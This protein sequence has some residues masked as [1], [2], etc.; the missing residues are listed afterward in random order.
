MS[1]ELKKDYSI[2]KN[3]TTPTTWTVNEIAQALTSQ[4]KGNKRIEVPTFQ[5]SLVWSDEQ[6][7]VFIDSLRNGFP[8]GTL[9][10]YE[11]NA[12]LYTLIDGLQRGSTIKDFIN[13][14]TKYFGERDIDDEVLNDIVN[15]F[16]FEGGKNEFKEKV[17]KE[18]KKII[19]SMEWETDNIQNLQVSIAEKLVEC[20]EFKEG[21][22]E[23]DLS[24]KITPCVTNYTK[25][26]DEI[27]NIRVPVLVFSG[28]ES[29]LP[30]VFERINNM[31]TQL[32][33]YEIYASTWAVHGYTKKVD[34]DEILSKIIEKY[35]SFESEGYTLEGYDKTEL[36]TSREVSIFEYGLGFGKYICE[37]YEYLFESDD[38]DQEINQ[39]G[40]E[41]LNACFK[42]PLTDIKE[43]DEFLNRVD[44]NKLEERVLEAID[45]V[46]SAL[47]PYIKFKGNSRNKGKSKKRLIYHPKNQIISMIS[48]TFREKYGYYDEENDD[49]IRMNLDVENETWDNNQKKLNSYLPHHYLYDIIGKYWSEGSG[50]KI[51]K[52]LDDNRYLK[53]INKFTWKSRLDEWFTE[54]MERSEKKKVKNATND[55]KLFLNYVFVTNFSAYD[56]ES[57]D[58]KFDIEHLAP[59]KQMR[60]FI[61]KNDWPGLPIS[62][63]GNLCYLPEYDNRKKQD[64]TIYQDEKYLKAIESKGYS[65]EDIEKK[66]TL[67]QE[68]D[69]QWLNEEYSSEDYE[70]FKKSYIN[71]L[72][73]HFIKL[74]NELYKQLDLE[75]VEEI[76]EENNSE[77]NNSN[78]E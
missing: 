27:K 54:S 30:T 44:I 69:L 59:K 14:P 21:K 74:K 36:E 45:F 28:S 25:L 78:E 18:I 15:F 55:E 61:E 6:K 3:D 57:D 31:G 64:N 24:K 23:L 9:L 43:L 12:E 17:S 52:I 65:I 49:E 73:K 70:T 60:S 48:T 62:S 2:I 39:V 37:K 50:H 75:F 35:D 46:N 42:Q 77:G 13:N 68:E 32:S 8:V 7:E 10:F 71:F 63:V 56:Q 47:K 11:R 51:S 38:N 33:K 19:N 66:Y 40:F 58:K 26:F 29:D 1:E 5:R 16:V 41:I 67:T 76:P 20:F 53:P 4:S 22:S 34:N 72:K